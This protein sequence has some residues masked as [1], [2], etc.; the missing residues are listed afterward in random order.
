MQE[1]KKLEDIIKELPEDLIKEVEDFT[2][3]LLEKRKREETE[4]KKLTLS[5][6]GGLSEFKNKYTSVELQHKALEWTVDKV[7]V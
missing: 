7:K 5:W 1:A 2:L 3:F 4:K 6:A